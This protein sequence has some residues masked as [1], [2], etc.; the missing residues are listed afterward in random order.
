MPLLQPA[1]R[2]HLFL[3]VLSI[4]LRGDM[5]SH[6]ISAMDGFGLAVEL[7]AEYLCSA[8]AWFSTKPSAGERL[9]A[10]Q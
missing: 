3:T 6:G 4:V 5:G 8:K 10:V 9:C 2:K 1:R 7:Y